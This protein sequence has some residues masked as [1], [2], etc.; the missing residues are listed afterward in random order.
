[1]LYVRKKIVKKQEEVKLQSHLKLSNTV[2]NMDH[3]KLFEFTAAVRGYHYFQ[4]FW[5]PQ[6]N[7]KLS[8]VYEENNL[9]DFF[10]TKICEDINI[11]GHLPIG[12]SRASKYL[13][14]HGA[15]FTM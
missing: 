3:N 5:E 7:Q 14:G 2:Q 10:A 15:S 4:R 13:M 8:C 1:M 9:F 6:P 11:V 12:I